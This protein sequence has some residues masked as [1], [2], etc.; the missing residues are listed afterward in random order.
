MLWRH[1]KIFSKA[2]NKIL[3][4]VHITLYSFH[5]NITRYKSIFDFQRDMYTLNDCYEIDFLA[6]D[7]S[8]VMGQVFW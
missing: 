4:F 6:G 2:F 1:V 5:S 7:I 3:N 8:F